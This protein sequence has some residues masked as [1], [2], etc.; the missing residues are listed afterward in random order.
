MELVTATGHRRIPADREQRWMLASTT[1][2]RIGAKLGGVRDLTA[3]WKEASPMSNRDFGCIALGRFL[4]VERYLES[5]QPSST[6]PQRSP[7]ADRTD[8]YA[9]T[10]DSRSGL[11]A[12]ARSRHG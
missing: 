7:R 4:A 6:D 11:R 5:Q 8:R 2:R 9:D 12:P 3:Y 1:C 10:P